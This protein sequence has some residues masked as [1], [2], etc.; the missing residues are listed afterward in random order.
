MNGSNF[1]TKPAV[2]AACGIGVGVL[3][4]ASLKGGSGVS[5]SF[6][7]TSQPR[8]AVTTPVRN[9]AAAM[10]LQQLDE[11][12]A[13]VSDMVAPSVVH[14]RA[15]DARMPG[16]VGGQGSGF[17]YSSDGWI[18][19]ND[20]VVEGKK[21]VTVI[22]NDGREVKGKVTASGDARND[23]ALVKVAVNDLVPAKIADSTTVRVGQFAIAF[24]APFGLENSVTIGHISALGRAS[25]AGGM[26][27]TQRTYASMIQT[28]AP[29]NPGNSG[30]PL[31]NIYGEV[32]GVNTSILGSGGGFGE[33]G[34][35]GIGFAIPANQVRLIADK[36]ISTGKLE[37]GF[38]GVLPGDLTPYELK[39]KKAVEGAIVRDMPASNS[40]AGN[41]SIAKNDIIV[42]IDKKR[43]RGQQDLLNAMLD[44][45][46]GTVVPVKF[47][48]DG[49]EKTVTVKV[50]EMPQMVAQQQPNRRGFQF[51]D[52]NPNGEGWQR[53][54]GD[55]EP[56]APERTPRIEREAGGKAQ[57][58][59]MVKTLDEDDRKNFKIP[60]SVK[61]AVVTS[62]EPGS[63][64]EE[65][66]LQA[67]DV[68]TS[69]NGRS[70]SSADELLEVLKDK[71]VGDPGTITVNRFEDGGQVTNS[72]NFTY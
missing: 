1:W 41:A 43:I 29:I 54:F 17:V 61:G 33:P 14:I 11:A 9:G 19:T 46:P 65:L 47:I 52:L 27:A 57:L 35:V 48:R 5:S 32:I 36:L 68:I 15:E 62:V 72:Q 56:G 26:G 20:H 25:T 7:N 44:I 18:I 51:P 28:D 31:V 69:L 2:W 45:K 55:Q 34:N 30:G 39:Q 22:F 42:Q 63:V 53:F 67:G 38:L 16:G 40:P 70:I 37:R 24:G 4:T 12:F 6:L 59:V 71:K 13:D 23:I 3:A 58:G 49:K 64:G 8:V 21:E 10:S 50:G 60:E 66:N